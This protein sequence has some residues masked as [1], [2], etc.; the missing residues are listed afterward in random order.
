MRTDDDPWPNDECALAE[1]VAYGVFAQHLEGA[2][3]PVVR[4][5]SVDRSVAELR[6]VALFVDGRAEVGV[7]RDARDEA[8][9]AGSDERLG[10]GADDVWHVPARVD[11]RVPSSAP[12]RGEVAFSVPG[13]LLDLGVQVRV[14]AAAVEERQLVAPGESRVRKRTPDEPR[15]AED[16]QLHVSSASPARSRSTSSSVL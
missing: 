11:H 9:E 15:T 1:H 16:E 5:Q 10:G 12:E 6:E 13:E 2:V 4:K 3:V 8:V 7:G 14:R